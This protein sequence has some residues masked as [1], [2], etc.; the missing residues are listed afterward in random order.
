MS[1]GSVPVGS[2][3]RY[4]PRSTA[5]RMECRLLWQGD[6]THEEKVTTDNIESEVSAR[7]CKP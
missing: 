1:C 2:E 5:H 6:R 4:S 7:I 3:K